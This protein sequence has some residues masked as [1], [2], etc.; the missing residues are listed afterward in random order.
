MY[1]LPDEQILGARVLLRTPEKRDADAIVAACADPVLIRFLPMIA[2]PYRRQDA[3]AWIASA[4][5]A[6]QQGGASFVIADPATDQVLGSIGLHDVS[7]VE[8]NGEIGYW[9]A[10]WA[11]NR[12]VAADGT[13]TLTAWAHVHGLDRLALLTEQ[14]N[15]PSQKVALA[16]GYRREGL[17]RGRGRSRDGGRHDLIVWARLSGDPAPTVR[18]LPDLSGPPDEYGRPTRP[19]PHGFLTDGVVT[20]RPLWESDAPGHYELDT[21]PEVVS[22]SVPP[23]APALADVVR[24]CARSY[25][26]WLAGERCELVIS[27][28][29]TGEFAGQIALV[30]SEPVSGQAMVGYG[31][32]PR[33]RGRGFTTRA[34]RL[35]T[36]WAF[37]RTDIRR[38]IAGTAP[39]NTAS[40]AVLQRAGFRREG[41]QYSRLPG[42]GGTRIDDVLWALLPSSAPP[43]RGGDD[44]VEADQARTFQPGGLAVEDRQ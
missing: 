18:A 39:E 19:G 1:G 42:V 8:G 13:R 32:L 3:L 29:T 40:Q 10:P 17:A 23:V 7:A 41:Y 15:W 24:R 16:C 14:E 25:S 31:L 12:G 2:T 4:P 28:A 20:L 34:V 30:Y 6:R 43:E 11:R 35:L 21:L 5:A 26:R 38:I 37:R 9:V 33:F 36:G 44:H 22:T 27:D